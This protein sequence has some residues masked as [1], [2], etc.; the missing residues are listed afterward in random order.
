MRFK[1]EIDMSMLQQK[2][3]KLFVKTQQVKTNPLNTEDSN[4]P[5]C[6]DRSARPS[7]K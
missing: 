4:G 1:P 3:L 7:K 5:D 6:S 2:T